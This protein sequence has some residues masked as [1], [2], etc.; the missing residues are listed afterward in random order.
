MNEGAFFQDLAMLMAAAGLVSVVFSKLK[1]PK[2]AGYILAGVL[3]GKYTWGGS[4]L[5]DAVLE[6]N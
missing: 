4:F 5:A 3:L 1:F 6:C 2:V